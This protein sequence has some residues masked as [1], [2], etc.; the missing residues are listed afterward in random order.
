[1]IISFEISL[2]T[3]LTSSIREFLNQ[4]IIHAQIFPL[5][6]AYFN[7]WKT[8]HRKLISFNQTNRKLTMKMIMRIQLRVTAQRSPIA[9]KCQKQTTALKVCYQ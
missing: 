1:M 6:L 5:F 2:M 4:F 3:I 9:L 8:N 7:S